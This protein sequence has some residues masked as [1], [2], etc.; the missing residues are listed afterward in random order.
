M[1]A[2]RLSH[3]PSP[4]TPSPMP[5]WTWSISTGP[6]SSQ[7]PSPS[8]PTQS[9]PASRSRGSEQGLRC[10]WVCVH[11]LSCPTWSRRKE[12]S[13]PSFQRTRVARVLG[14][15]DEAG[16]CLPNPLGS[17]AFPGWPQPP[18]LPHMETHVA[19]PARE[20]ARAAEGP[21]TLMPFSIRR[22]P[23]SCSW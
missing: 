15:K 4:T 23:W 10:L 14:P 11:E 1:P 19:R 20:L 7:P 8:H 6:T 17:P 12:D 21:K 5:T 13:Q 18:T 22:G 9:T 16:S 2:F 3:R